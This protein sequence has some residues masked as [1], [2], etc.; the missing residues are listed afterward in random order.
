[1]PARILL[2]ALA[3]VLWFSGN[4]V[5]EK[6]LA[7]VIGNDAYSNLPASQQLRKAGNDARA[8]A[9]TFRDLGFDTLLGLNLGRSEVNLKLQEFV[10]KVERGDTAAVFYAG[11]GVRIGGQNYLLPSDV[12]RIKSG[13]EAFLKSESVRVDTITDTLN[14]R[15]A[16]ITL[17]FLDACRDNPFNELTGRSVGGTRGLARMTPVQGTFIMFSA[18]A[19]QQALDR[20]SDSDANPNSVFTRAL[21]PLMKQPGLEIGEMAKQVKRSVYNLALTV[22]GHQ[23]TPAVY[24]EMLSDFY[25]A[26]DK[27]SAKRV[28]AAPAPA[29]PAAP[30]QDAEILFWQSV[31]ANPTKESYEAYLQ[32]YPSGQFASLAQA[33][34]AALAPP[35]PTKPEPETAQPE[36]GGGGLI[37]P[38]SHLRRLTVIELVRLNRARLRI[39]R[40]EIYARKG[41]FFKSKDLKIYFSR[42]PWYQPYTWNPKLTPLEKLNVRTILAVEKRK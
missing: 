39:A 16:K 21:L 9:Q 37:F 41:R 6:R 13:Q 29:V 27:G 7:L 20:V 24:N 18:G 14:A 26:G 3:T 31:T 30:K 17:L 10:N 11:H 23:Q 35:A 40:N 42:F 22:G 25:L 12:P 8:M 36:I 33:R 32:S 1:M 2:L 15:G 28:A 4:A 19:G 38:D 34:I 5:A